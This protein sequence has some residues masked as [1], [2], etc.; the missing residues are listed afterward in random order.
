MAWCVDQIGAAIELRRLG[1]VWL[2]LLAVQKKEFPHCKHAA[3]LEIEWG[4][5]LGRLALYRRQRLEIGKKIAHVLNLHA[6]GGGVGE[7]RIVVAGVGG[8][9]PSHGGGEGCFAS[10]AEATVVGPGGGWGG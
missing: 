9:G 3:D 7:N 2:E 5:V 10:G 4:V 8:G 1:R 6:L